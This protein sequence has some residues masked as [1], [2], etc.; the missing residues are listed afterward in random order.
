MQEAVVYIVYF[1]NIIDVWYTLCSKLFIRVQ[2]AFG[3]FA[4]RWLDESHR[5]AV[6][7][8]IT[9]V[10]LPEFGASFPESGRIYPICHRPT[11]TDWHYKHITGVATL[12]SPGYLKGREGCKLRHCV[13]QRD[14]C[15]ICA[16]DLSAKLRS[17][18][19]AGPELSRRICATLEKVWVV[20]FIKTLLASLTLISAI[21]SKVYF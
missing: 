2:V 20:K 8:L 4:A 12:A 11:L 10:A 19:W 21:L 7:Y 18:H 15:G 6:H 13:P 1:V 16:R 9:V 5:G 17:S 3:V 14:L